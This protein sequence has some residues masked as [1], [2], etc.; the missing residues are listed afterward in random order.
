MIN[1]LC[2]IGFKHRKVNDEKNKYAFFI[3]GGGTKGFYAIGVLK[4]LFEDNPYINLSDVK[5]FGGTSVGSYLATALSL[6][7]N[8]NDIIDVTDKIDLGN[9][10]DPSYMFMITS[11]RFLSRGYLYNDDGRKKIIETIISQ[12]IESINKH[13]ELNIR[14]NDLTIGHLKI[15]VERYPDVYKHLIVNTVDINTNEQLFMTSL[16]DDFLDIKIIDALLA[17][18]TIPFVFKPVILYQDIN[19]KKYSYIKTTN[20]TVNNLVDGGVSTNNPL[21]FFLL[22]NKIYDNYHLWLL[23]FTDI[24][25]YIKINGTLSLLKQLVSYLI[26]GKNDVKM[27][28]I[29]E[30]YKIN[31]INLHSKGGTL[32]IY[33][34]Q[35]I[36]DIINEVYKHCRDGHLFN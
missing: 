36:V 32:E 7:Y 29:E 26:G 19:T 3:E 6:G 24:P 27:E 9:L 16:N 23:K 12:K 8:K 35:Q 10:I 14:E 17:S 15:L 13:L 25:V 2:K 31:C 1:T 18:S 28:L 20:S 11:Y 22:N 33:T 30:M 4:Y 34:H 5:I 21:D